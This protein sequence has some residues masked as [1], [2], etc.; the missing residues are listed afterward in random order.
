MEPNVA[1]RLAYRIL[2]AIKTLD[3]FPNRYRLCTYQ[4]WK[5]KGLR[6]LPIGNYL[7]FYT[8]EEANCIVKIYRIIYGKRDLERQLED[9][10]EFE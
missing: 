8:T 2:Q 4:D 10:V 7:A 1:E 9:I 5:N 6:I 3:E